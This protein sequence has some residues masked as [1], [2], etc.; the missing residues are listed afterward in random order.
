ML[1]P[2]NHSH[3]VQASAPASSEFYHWL[4]EDELLD[5]AL[6]DR[7]AAWIEPELTMFTARFAHYAVSNDISESDR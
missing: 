6:C 5:E 7:F 1:N 3:R 4:Y 2:V